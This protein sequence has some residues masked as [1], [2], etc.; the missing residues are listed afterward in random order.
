MR[1][2]VDNP[3]L[4]QLFGGKPDQVAALVLGDRHLA[5]RR[6]AASCW[7]PGRPGLLRADAA[8]HQ[9][10]RRGDARPAQEPA[11]DLR[12]RDGA[13]RLPSSYAVGYLPHRRRCLG[14]RRN[15]VPALF[16]F[17]VIV[18]AAAGPA[19]DRPGQGHRL[20]AAARRCRRRSAGAAALLVVVALLAGSLSDANLLLVGTAATYAI[21]MLSLVLLTGYGGHVSLAQFTFAGVGALAYAKLDEPNLFGLLLVGADRRRRRRAGGAAGAAADRPLPRPGHAG[22]RARS[23][24]RW[25]SRP[26][27]RSASTAPCPPSGSRSSGTVDR[28]TGGYVLRDGGLLRADGAGRCC[29]SA[30]ACSAGC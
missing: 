23:W 22:V 26:T 12:R 27:S 10:V 30:A 5:G 20:R 11:A 16:L 6:S 4:L 18:A 15:V 24:T 28:S 3:E 29:C 13:R 25:S 19:A 1:A 8:G 21:V 14:L 2:S 17:V 7:R 9:R